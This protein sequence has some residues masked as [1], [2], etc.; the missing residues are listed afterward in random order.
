MKFTADL[1]SGIGEEK[2]QRNRIEYGAA[3]YPRAELAKL[4][5]R[6]INDRAHHRVIDAVPYTRESRHDKQESCIE[7]KNIG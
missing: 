2:C 3:H 5:L 7:Q 6:V 4:R 1:K